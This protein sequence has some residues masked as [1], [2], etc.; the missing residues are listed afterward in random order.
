MSVKE[1]QVGDTVMRRL[2]DNKPWMKMTVRAVTDQRLICAPPELEK[3]PLDELWH[4]DKETGAEWD[5]ELQWGPEFGRTGSYITK[6]L[7]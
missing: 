4:F 1:C 5:P 7:T 2:G 3:W 6:E